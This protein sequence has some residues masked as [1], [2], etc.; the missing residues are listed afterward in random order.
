[1]QNNRSNRISNKRSIGA[2]LSCAGGHYKALQSIADKGGNCLQIFSSSPRTWQQARIA[3]ADIAQ[4]NKIRTELHIDPIYFHALYL[5]NLADSGATGQKSVQALIHEMNLGVELGVKGS[6]V[7]TGSFKNKDKTLTCRDEQNYPTLLQNIRSILSST[8]P[9]SYLILEN[10]GNRKI[11]QTI[12]QLGEIVE[13]IN[14]DRL[15]ICLDTCHLHA[16]GYDLTTPDNFERFLDLFEK[17]IGLE[18]LE[19]LHMNDSLDPF[20]SLR[21][22]HENIGQGH[23]G[24]E[25]FAHFLNHPKT[26]HLPFIIETPGFD[27][28]GPD[29][30]NI[31]ILK[32]LVQ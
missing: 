24:I 22:R 17:L 7:H 23:V 19:V 31:D 1:M 21:D 29:K 25:V 15:R 32:S 18:E 16:A 3:P 12:E 11:G 8:P 2:H 20:G 30:K 5:V 10:A 6:I 26:K 13:D 28:K 14:N 27:Q 4:F 9:E